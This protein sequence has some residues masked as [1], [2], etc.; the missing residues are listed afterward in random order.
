MKKGLVL[1]LI[2]LCSF[3]VACGS[4]VPDIPVVGSEASDVGNDYSTLRDLLSEGKYEEADQETLRLSLSASKSLEE[5]LKAKKEELEEAGKDSSIFLFGK[6]IAGLD[7]KN[8]FL[9]ESIDE[10]PC[11]DLQTIDQLW[12]AYSNGKF[13]FSIQN[14]ILNEIGTSEGERGSISDEFLLQVGWTKVDASGNKQEVNLDQRDFS[15]NAPEGHLPSGSVLGGT[16]AQVG[17]DP[18]FGVE[19]LAP[20]IYPRLEAC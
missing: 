14:T 10:F 11:K 8:S 9:I 1:L 18:V 17:G 2:S 20:Y 5:S 13:G 16:I 6:D 4:R 12:T 7:P 15:K 19:R 3:S